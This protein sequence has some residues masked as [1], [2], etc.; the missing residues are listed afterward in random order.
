MPSYGII[1]T[2]M[3]CELVGE[4]IPFPKFPEF[5]GKNSTRRKIT[6]EILEVKNAISEVTFN[7]KKN[8][9]II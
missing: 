5:Y 3:P 9:I 6:R 4:Q 8:I 2:I 1:S 7:C